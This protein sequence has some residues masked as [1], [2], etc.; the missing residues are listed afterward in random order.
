MQ[1]FEAK[2][3]ERGLAFTSQRR[4]VAKVLTE[5]SDH[6]DIDQIYLRSKMIDASVSIATVY[7]TVNLF[8][9]LDLVEKRDFG[10]GKNRYEESKD[11]DGGDH[12]HIVDVDS[13]DVME[14]YSNEI[15]DMIEK[16][17]EQR[18]LKL[19]E[20]NIDVYCKKVTTKQ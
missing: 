4:I 3:R 12:Y 10:D 16:I 11:G 1:N 15:R 7:R 9:E 6:P 2:F 18:G 20:H 13:G 8:V 19:I 14:F 5:S 17:L